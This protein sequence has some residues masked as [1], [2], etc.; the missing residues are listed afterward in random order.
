MTL[1]EDYTRTAPF[2]RQ[3]NS[4]NGIETKCWFF[5]SSRDAETLLRILLQRLLIWGRS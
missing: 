2:R 4:C 1:K 3:E 5:K